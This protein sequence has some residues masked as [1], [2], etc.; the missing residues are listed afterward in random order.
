MTALMAPP[1]LPVV[2]PA[3]PGLTLRR[4]SVDEYHRMLHSGIIREDEPYELLEGWIVEKMSHN[5]PHDLVV[6]L[7]DDE[8]I[9]LVPAGWFRRGQS[10]VTTSDSEPEPDLAL[11]RGKR[12]DYEGRHPA[13][14]DMGLVVEVADSS[15]VRD[16]IV[17][18]RIYA[19]GGVPVYWIV[20]IQEEQ[21]EVYTKPTGNCDAPAFG[22]RQDYRRGDAVPL[23]LGDVEIGRIAVDDLL[24]SPDAE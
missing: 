17:K 13:P 6:G 16:R 11:V 23:M 15:L 4:F 10:S 7:V 9:R 5:P 14:D 18:A 21:V 8:F 2:T 1:A 3:S 20:N 22:V 12:R 24:P 19:R